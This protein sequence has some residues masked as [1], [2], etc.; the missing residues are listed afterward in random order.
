MGLMQSVKPFH[1]SIVRIIRKNKGELEATGSAFLV[2]SGQNKSLF[3]TCDHNFEEEKGES[4]IRLCNGKKKITLLRR[5]FGEVIIQ[6]M[7]SCYFRLI[8]CLNLNVWSSLL[9]K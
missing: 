9:K 2:Y 3:L 4:F 6:N 5:S 8:R 7:I 1:E